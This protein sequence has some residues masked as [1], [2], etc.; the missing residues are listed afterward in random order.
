[1]RAVLTVRSVIERDEVRCVYQPIVDLDSGCVVAVEGLARGPQ[2]SPL[3]S[4]AALFAA[5]ACEGVLTELDWA[6]R[7]AAVRGALEAEL[8][9]S[10]RLFINAEPSSFRIAAPPELRE[11]FEHAASRLSIVIEVTERAIAADPASLLATLRRVRAL[12]FDVAIDD[13]GAE[14]ASLALMPFIGPD[15]IKLDM[16]LVRNPVGRSTAA[17]MSAVQADAERR[18]ALILAEGIETDVHLERALVAGAHLGQGWRFGRPGSLDALTLP[19]HAMTTTRCTLTATAAT[20]WSLIEGTGVFRTTTKR[21]LMPMSDHMERLALQD[22]GRSVLLSAFQNVSHFTPATAR[23]Y[24]ELAAHC[25]LVGA[26]GVGMPSEP[27]AGVRGAHIDDRH[28]LV[29]EWTVAV[30]G[31]HHAAALIAQD[32]GDTG[33]DGD[34]RFDYLI[35][36]DRDLVIAAGRSLMQHVEPVAVA[37][38]VELM[39]ASAA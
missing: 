16:D 21:L 20:P 10:C 38:Q 30:I 19:E 13:V 26:L 34:R 3:E 14:P 25:A 29:G 7:A 9:A 1:M 2:G 8:P 35:T 27:V 31:P 39:H 23:R 36:H 4:P 5:A 18:G 6:C 15:V 37:G 22:A 24:A 28:P 17:L 32:R 33:P 11:L 12:G